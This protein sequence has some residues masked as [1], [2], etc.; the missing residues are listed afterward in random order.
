VTISEISLYGEYP[1]CIA[2]Q[3]IEDE[4]VIGKFYQACVSMPVYMC[5]REGVFGQLICTTSFS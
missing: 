4:Q 3:I 5:N 2:S 1:M